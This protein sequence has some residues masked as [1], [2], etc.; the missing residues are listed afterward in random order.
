MAIKGET[1]KTLILF[2]ASCT[3]VLNI[4]AQG[5]TLGD[6]RSAQTGNWSA[7]AS[8][9][10]FDGSAWVAASST[11]TS[12]NAGVITLR[13][14]HTVTVTANVTADQVVLASG[15][16][17]TINSG[18]TWTIANGAG[19][20][21][22]VSGTVRN[23]GTITVNSGATVQ[24][25]SSSLYIHNDLG[26][27]GSAIPIAA[28]DAASTCQIVLIKSSAASSLG[29]AFGNITW[30]SPSQGDDV[31][32]PSGVS[33]GGN[34]AVVA[35]PKYIRFNK[36]S[37][38]RTVAV[39]GN[40][41]I[42]GGLVVVA[43]DAGATTIVV[44]G[45]FSQ[46]GGTF[47]LGE[48]NGA[49]VL[50]VKDSF[51]HSGG[52]L[53]RKNSS[54]SGTIEFAG[55]GI[56]NLTAGG[57]Y[58][59]GVESRVHFTANTGSTLYL[60]ANLLGGGG[61]GTSSGNFTLQSGATLGIGHA[62][63]I[64]SSGAS[65][66]IR[67]TGTRTYSTG[68]NYVYNGTSAQ[69]TGNGLPS[70]VNSLTLSGSGTKTISASLTVSGDFTTSG[71][72]A[73][74]A[75]GGLTMNGNFTVESG[76]SFNA[77]SYSHTVRGNWIVNG[78]FTPGTS[79]FTFSGSAAQSKT[80]STMYNLTINN[81]AGVAVQTS[82]ETVANTLTLTS[83]NISTGTTTLT[84]GT[85]PASPGTLSRSSGTIVGNF[86]RWFASAIASNV[87]FPVGTSTHYRPANISFTVAPSVGGTLTAFFLSSNPGASGLPLDEAGVSIVNAGV[88]GFWTLVAGDGLTGGTYSLDLTADGFSGVS[89]FTALRILKRSSSSSPWT[90][91]GTHSPGTGSNATPIVHRSG[92]SG[93]S[94]FGIGT[95]FDNP[96][97]IQ[98]LS[99]TAIV[100][101][102]NQVQL[103][104][105]TLTETNNYGFVVQKSVGTPE[106]YQSIPN[107]FIAGHGTTL[108][109]QSYS[110]VD[111]S[112][113]AGTMYYRLMQIDL[114]G[115][116]H[117]TDG[118]QINV[119]TGVYED[120]LPTQFA[121][122]QNFPNP[123]NPSTKIEFTIPREGR[124]TLEIFDMLGQ[125]V[126]TLLDEMRQVGSH[127]EQFIAGGLASGQYFYRLQAGE[128]SIVKRMLLVR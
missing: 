3:V 76:S 59:S 104:W 30:N 111:S 64:T 2:V 112:A 101:N 114:D 56:Q 120:P 27:I 121:L 50:R 16:S 24:F 82:D 61:S 15:S 39:S 75:G 35:N 62:A 69:S 5:Q 119:L 9:Q 54:G 37:S 83:G 117:Y 125:K 106:N 72:A 97:P 74:V 109:P 8:W 58:P 107:C 38:P 25:Q 85:S 108:V 124:V 14:G 10:R 28:W 60:G 79:T 86:R 96:L 81:F 99:F 110:Y 13:N 7:T 88:D 84:L 105:T 26:G 19:T 128:A 118:I 29:Q 36:T 67:V 65:G 46:S 21:L 33:A 47:D 98:L 93:F 122:S 12:G 34:F 73:G 6:Y 71:T 77:S 102:Q 18:L 70:T 41:T 116:I 115:T 20:D 53:Q 49:G 52:T 94:E 103:D 127:S 40:M 22:S 91:D 11:P 80:G 123:F 48:G 113:A 57:N 32:F 1:I 51:S 17:V 31:D 42:Q 55:S 68:A 100:V 44:D 43:G 87:L 89:D 63:G 45:S 90:L 95:P 66:N 78:T 23:N 126:V 4:T 92:M